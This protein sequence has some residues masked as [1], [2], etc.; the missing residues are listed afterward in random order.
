M[1]NFGHIIKE[2]IKGHNP[3][4]PQILDHSYIILII[5]GFGSG[6]TSELFDLIDLQLDVNQ[7]ICVIR[8]HLKPNTNC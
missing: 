8:I 1:I 2:D 3:N 5:G 4:L 7:F 6:K